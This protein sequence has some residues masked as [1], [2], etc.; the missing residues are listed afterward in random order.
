MK[1]DTRQCRELHGFS[2]WKWSKLPEHAV[3]KHW[4]I[5][6][7]FH[8][9]DGAALHDLERIGEHDFHEQRGGPRSENG[10]GWKRPVQEGKCTDMVGMSVGDH[11]GV[12]GFVLQTCQIREWIGVAIQADTRINDNPL[13]CQFNGQTTGTNATGPSNE[14]HLHFWSFPSLFSCNTH[15]VVSADGDQ[16]T[17]QAIAQHAFDDG[18]FPAIVRFCLRLFKPTGA[19]QLQRK[20]DA[21][22]G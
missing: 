19:F 21:N 1:R 2:D 18:S 10:S 4:G 11:N 6:W 3:Y 15:L 5:Q 20:T 8:L 9:L 14:D 12:N 22:C 17:V 7:Q 16:T 13:S